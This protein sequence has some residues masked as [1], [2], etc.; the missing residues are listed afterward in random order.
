MKEYFVKFTIPILMSGMG[1]PEPE[2]VG[3]VAY[4][5]LKDNDLA[6]FTSIVV[7]DIDSGAETGLDPLDLE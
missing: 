1:N 7:I 3:R 6:D 4:D 5:R 2:E